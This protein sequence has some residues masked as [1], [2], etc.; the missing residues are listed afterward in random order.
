MDPANQ[1]EVSGDKIEIDESQDEV[2]KDDSSSGYSESK[3]D[4]ESSDA[5]EVVDLQS[6]S[7]SR[8][9]ERKEEDKD[10]LREAKFRISVLQRWTEEEHEAFVIGVKE[11]GKD[12]GKIADLIKTKSRMQVKSHAFQIRKLD[13]FT[14]SKFTKDKSPEEI[15]V[16][17]E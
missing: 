15:K 7:S 9:R 16:L 6:S 1:S 8:K 3:S 17:F 11:F 12:Y 13:E 4:A 14:K 2:E 10:I 5:S